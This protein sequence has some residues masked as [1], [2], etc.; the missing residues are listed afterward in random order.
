MK[1]FRGMGE[2]HFLVQNSRIEQSIYALN[3]CSHNRTTKS[4]LIGAKNI[5]VLTGKMSPVIFLWFAQV[6]QKQSLVCKKCSKGL[7]KS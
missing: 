1:T 4:L 3:Q 5:S 6:L 2:I 7:L